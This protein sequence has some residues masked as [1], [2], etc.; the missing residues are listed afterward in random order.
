MHMD[1]IHLFTKTERELATLIQ[2]VRIYNQYI[3]VEYSIENRHA[4]NEKR[5][6]KHDGSDRPN[7]PRKN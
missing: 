5:E 7:K 2:T 6:T 1:D 3:G 4:N